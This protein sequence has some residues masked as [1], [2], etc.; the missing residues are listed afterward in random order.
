MSIPAKAVQELPLPGCR[1]WP[2]DEPH[3][4]TIV[5]GDKSTSVITEENDI[6]E[7][8]RASATRDRDVG[9]AI[10]SAETSASRT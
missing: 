5:D 9:I 6:A 8:E 3:A 1:F 10:K 7:N 2:R 4:I